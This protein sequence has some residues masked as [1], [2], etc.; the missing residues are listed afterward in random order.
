MLCCDEGENG[1]AEAHDARTAS[2]VQVRA[3]AK[4]GMA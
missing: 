4:G 2:P 1:V 3:K